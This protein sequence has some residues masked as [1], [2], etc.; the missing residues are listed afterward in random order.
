MPA[1]RKAP[2]THQRGRGRPARLA[3]LPPEPMPHGLSRARKATKEM[4]ESFFTSGQWATWDDLKRSRARD[5]VRIHDEA[6]RAEGSRRVA[7][8]KEVRLALARLASAT[9][10]PATSSHDTWRAERNA[11]R[12]ADPCQPCNWTELS[13]GDR[14]KCE[15]AP[16]VTDEA[17]DFSTPAGR[18]RAVQA[19]DSKGITK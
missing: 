10:D 6:E 8:V 15:L 3:P 4:W 9:A 5:L 19:Y 18:V 11:E 16:L 2:G 13:G 12:R 14:A 7:L 17:L 1:R